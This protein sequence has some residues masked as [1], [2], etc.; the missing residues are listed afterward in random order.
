MGTVIRLRY[1]VQVKR[2]V[3]V[4]G[5]YQGGSRRG[6]F[7]V[8]NYLEHTCLLSTSPGRSS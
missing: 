7:F 4:V 6:V 2:C 5:W 8:N 1:E 3:V